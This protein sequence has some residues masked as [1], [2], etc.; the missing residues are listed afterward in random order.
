[1]SDDALYIAL[2]A[3][4]RAVQLSLTLS[5][6]LCQSNGVPVG[7]PNVAPTARAVTVCV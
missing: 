4:V 2:N 1:M 6:R 7:E 5:I 3:S